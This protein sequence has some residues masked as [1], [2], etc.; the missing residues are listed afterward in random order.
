MNTIRGRLVAGFI[1]IIFMMGTVILLLM[2]FG[3][4]AQQESTRYN[5]ALLAEHGLI[6]STQELVRTF[7][8]FRNAPNTEHEEE[9]QAA[10]E[11]LQAGVQHVSDHATQGVHR[12]AIVGITNIIETLI[13]T[14]DVG[15]EA[16]RAE[17]L[18]RA[19][20]AYGEAARISTIVEGSISSLLLEEL[21]VSRDAREAAARRN[22]YVI[23]GGIV[24]L[25][26]SVTGSFLYAMSLSRT[27]A[28]PITQL[29]AVT[30]QIAAGSYDV[31]IDSHLLESTDEAGVLAR[32]FEAMAVNLRET[33]SGLRDAREAAT[34]AQADTQQKNDLLEQLNRLFISREARIGELKEDIVRL[35]GTVETL[36]GE[37]S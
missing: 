11:A 28:Q 19:G 32:S 31:H 6:S 20:D 18:E 35:G 25:L 3:A 13:R 29:T 34:K 10:R 2:L 4:A 26:L 37:R 9:Y 23:Y 30:A 21:E 14:T 17:D 7:N 1:T 8:Q 33:V 36:P 12:P 24:A 22:W 27:I 5:E 15:V 16:V